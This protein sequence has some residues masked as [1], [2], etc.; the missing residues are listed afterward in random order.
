MD[1]QDLLP[2]RERP[3]VA[4]AVSKDATA[5]R[6]K[7]G[8]LR[9]GAS[10][11][12]R[13]DRRPPRAQVIS[14]GEANTG[15]SCLI[16]RYCENRFVTKYV[17]TVGVDF[18]V[19]P[20]DVNGQ[21]IKVNFFDL[22]GNDHFVEVRNEYYKD[23][24]GVILVYDVARRAT[25]DALPRWIAEMEKYGAKAPAVVV[26]GNKTDTGQRAV[27]TAEARTWAQQRGFLFYET[28]AES[29]ENVAA[30]FNAVFG[31]VA[32]QINL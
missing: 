3:Q 24:Q 28:S 21:R 6:A 5:P 1:D 13:S 15:K 26:C 14:A 27:K 20:V 19:K 23:T 17:A 7:V 4:Q 32:A 9:S 12:P 22:A 30:A 2:A 25:F 18:G 11:G 8:L 10:F 29:G 16:K 31:M